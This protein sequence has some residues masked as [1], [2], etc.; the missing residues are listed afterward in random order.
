MRP[1][2][3]LSIANVGP[4]HADLAQSSGAFSFYH[5]VFLPFNA[6]THIALTPGY[7]DQPV[8]TLVG[9]ACT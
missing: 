4:G 2:D 1:A 7:S 9:T 5:A 6:T 8:P 3:L